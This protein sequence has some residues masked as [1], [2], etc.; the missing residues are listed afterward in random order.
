MIRHYE[1]DRSGRGLQR[2]GRRR[3]KGGRVAAQIVRELQDSKGVY[4]PQKWEDL[5]ENAD[6]EI[7][8]KS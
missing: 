2:I 6:H 4:P 8:P 1:H 7:S 3:V 5:K